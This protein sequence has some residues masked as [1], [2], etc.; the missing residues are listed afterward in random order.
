MRRL[1]YKI[2]GYMLIRNYKV[3]LGAMTH[4]EKEVI[5]KLE[6]KKDTSKLHHYG[7]NNLKELMYN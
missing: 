4:L 1:L 6:D 5:K 7:V 3:L 2:W